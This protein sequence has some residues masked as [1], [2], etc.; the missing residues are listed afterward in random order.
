MNV[1]AEKKEK[2]YTSAY[3]SWIFEFLSHM[4]EI[5][6]QVSSAERPSYKMALQHMHFLP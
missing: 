4:M 2:N 5:S 3:C 1:Y 6:M